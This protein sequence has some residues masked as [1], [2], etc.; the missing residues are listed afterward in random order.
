ML[1]HIFRLSYNPIMNSSIFKAYDIRGIVPDEISDDVAM[2]VGRAFAF[3]LRTETGKKRVTIAV[4]QDNRVHSP[5]LFRALVCGLTSSGADVVDIGLSSTPSFYFAV[6]HCNLDGGIMVTA[7]HNPPEYNGFKCVRKRAEPIGV[8][9]GLREIQALVEKIET[10]VTSADVLDDYVKRNLRLAPANDWS[11]LRVAVDTGNGVS[12]LMMQGLIDATSL[13][14][15]PL[16]FELDGTFP[17][18]LPNPLKE[19]NIAVLKKTVIEQHCSCGIALDADG[20]RSVFVDEKGETV[21][22]DLVCALVASVLLKKNSGEKI[23][24][25]AT[26]SWA[27]REAIREHGGIP[28]ISRVGHSFIKETMR[29]ENILFAGERSGHFY[30]R[31]SN[32]GYFEA[33]LLVF[34]IVLNLM[35]ET[36]QTLSSLIAPFLRYAATGEINFEV[37][38]TDRVTW[39]IEKYY[40]DAKTVD[41]L[42]GLTIEYADW[43]FNLRPSNTESLLRLNLEARTA[44]VRDEKL[45]ELTALIVGNQE[46]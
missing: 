27:T 16:Y 15:V 41:R 3:F 25:D 12:A 1:A 31:F 6:S 13:S 8:Q 39:R 40:T 20:D 36:R 21:P 35:A 38:D 28:I 19:E 5:Q 11:S 17:N 26:S 24:Y 23:C 2:R 7:S 10:R 42:D 45:K 37:G 30:F 44:A 34:T 4:G 9:T 29:A 33:P 43:W 22:S 18:H 14:V 32:L 46:L